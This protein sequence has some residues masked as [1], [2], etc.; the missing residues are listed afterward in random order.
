MHVD[1]TRVRT[2]DQPLENATIV[3]EEMLS[4]LREM[5]GF[6]GFLVMSQEGTSIGLSFW[7]SREAAERHRAVRRE[8]IGRMTS[9]AD[10]EV[11]ETTSYELMFAHLA[12]VAGAVS[13]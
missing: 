7:E 3:A 5:D 12:G 6:R 10:I 1:L 8:F 9:V 11:E 13:E 4:W 2:S